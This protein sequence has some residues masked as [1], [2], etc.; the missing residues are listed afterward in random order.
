MVIPRRLKSSLK[1][2]CACVVLAVASGGR[3]DAPTQPPRNPYEPAI[4]ALWDG[5]YAQFEAGLKNGGRPEP[6]KSPFVLDE[7]SLCLSIDKTPLGVQ[8]RRTRAL[9]ADLK[10]MPG[11]P[12]LREI[13]KRVNDIAAQA[14]DPQNDKRLFMEL[15]DLTRQ[16]ALSNPLLNFDD[17]VVMGYTRPFSTSDFSSTL[18][19]LGLVLKFRRM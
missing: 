2:A 6:G 8:L 3:A 9:L 12:D 10:K 15:R 13:E 11:A 17:L 16:A 5:L 18:T 4:R 7:Q 19:R 14:D 1:V